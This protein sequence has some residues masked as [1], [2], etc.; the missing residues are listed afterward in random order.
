MP[1]DIKLT[2]PINYRLKTHK[3][4]ALDQRN[5]DNGVEDL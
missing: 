2:V 5:T 3:K 4:I 1:N